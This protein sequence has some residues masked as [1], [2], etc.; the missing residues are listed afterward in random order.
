MLFFCSQQESI[1]YISVRRP[2]VPAVVRRKKPSP[3]SYGLVKIRPRVGTSPFLQS[4]G[5]V[6]DFPSMLA[7]AGFW[8][9]WQNYLVSKHWYYLYWTFRKQIELYNN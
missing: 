9:V 7:A 2:L 3:H 4:M 6:F 5:S 8:F 1:K